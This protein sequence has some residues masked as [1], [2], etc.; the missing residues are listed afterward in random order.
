M[1]VGSDEGDHLGPV[2]L[3]TDIFDCLGDARVSSQVVVVIG[4][5]DIQLDILIVGKIE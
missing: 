2:E 5:R 1:D 3:M 4:A